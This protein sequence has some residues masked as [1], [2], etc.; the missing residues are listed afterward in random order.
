MTLARLLALLREVNAAPPAS[1]P[2]DLRTPAER[3]ADEFRTYLRKDRGMSES[4]I[5][6]YSFSVQ[7]F[8][9]RIFGRGPVTFR[10]LTG[11][12]VTDFLP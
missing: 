11:C 8:L 9:K 4:S 1:T 7:S 3:C 12:D 6:G 5:Y 2:P 10:K